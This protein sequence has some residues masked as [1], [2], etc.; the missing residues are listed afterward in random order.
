MLQELA[1]QAGTDPEGALL[2]C[3]Q[4]LARHPD[5]LPVLCL[6]AGLQRR[7][8]RLDDAA[9]ML[10]RAARVDGT[11]A[12][13]LAESAALAMARGQPSVAARQ[14]RALLASTPDRPDAWFN[15]GIAEEQAGRHQ[16][17]IDAF[18][19]MMR[20][21]ST[22]RPEVLARVAGLL[23][24]LGREAEARER[25]ERALGIDPGHPEARYVLG[26]LL[27]AEGRTEAAREAFRQCIARRPRFAEAWQQLLESR[28][29]EDPDDAELAAARSLLDD[30]AMGEGDRERLAF[31]VGK[32]LDDLGR[33]DDAFAAISLAKGLKGRRLPAF[34]PQRLRV[35]T[36]GRIRAPAR[37]SPFVPDAELTPVFIVGMP[38]SGTTLADQ[39][40][41]A[42]PEASGLG[43]LAFFDEAAAGFYADDPDPA[44]YGGLRQ[45]YLQRL[46]GTGHR[47]VSNKY[48]A[49][50]RNLSLIRWLLPE[51]RFVHVRRAALDNCLSVYFQDFPLGN[52]YANRMEDIAAYYREYRRLMAHWAEGK[53]DVFELSYEA[54]LR[55]QAGVTRELLA[56]CGLG[57]DEACLRYAD[58]P[59]PVATLSRWQVRQPLYTYSVGRWRRYRDHLTPLIEALGAFADES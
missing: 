43:E 13:V 18:E 58:N 10:E 33:S 9:A 3:R 11:A 14:L 55:D 7:A 30:P 37:P 53:P 52:L 29:V 46:A 56:F 5:N 45:A 8:G 2:R 40:L 42:H 28:R 17:A 39:I 47:V 25:L 44:A 54:L 41:T 22:P 31:A 27:M 15:L 38:R 26:M 51:A 59:R 19:Q 6:T 36:D 32:V 24:I 48:P 57:W 12:P 21:E 16:D 1:R 49:N 50:F 4:I 35:D 34:D 23:A 20:L